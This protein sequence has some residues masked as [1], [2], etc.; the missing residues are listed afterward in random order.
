MVPHLFRWT[1][2]ARTERKS[3]KSGARD[4]NRYNATGDRSANAMAAAAS[5]VADWD[6]LRREARRIEGDLDVR[7]SSYAKLGGGV[8]PR[9]FPPPPSPLPPPP[10]R[11]LVLIALASVNGC[12]LLGSEKP[13]ER[14]PLEVDGDGDRD[15]AGEADASER[16]DEQEFK[17]TRGNIMSMREHAELLI[18]VRNDINE[19]KA[20]GSTQ[21]AP[22]LLRERA[23]IH[24]SISQIDEVTSQAEEM[25]GILLAQR[26]TFSGIQGKVKQ[27]S[28]RFP[29]IRNI[30]GLYL[31]SRMIKRKKSKDT[32]ILSAVIAG[33]TLFIII[34][35]FSK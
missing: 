11:F 6:E 21:S 35:W 14:F 18:S 22:N 20:S 5:P 25:K 13:C 27:L 1:A 17:R 2:R 33:C 32:I 7:L 12:R 24:G 8:E 29:M 10:S 15:A 9:P 34:Y 23:A 3:H 26:S 19:H 28:D 4:R 31:S 30:L 16:G